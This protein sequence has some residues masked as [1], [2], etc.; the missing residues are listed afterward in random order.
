[1]KL[2]LETHCVKSKQLFYEAV[3]GRGWGAGV[4]WQASSAFPHFNPTRLKQQPIL[5]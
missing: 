5:L 3:F 2:Y 4:P 1:M